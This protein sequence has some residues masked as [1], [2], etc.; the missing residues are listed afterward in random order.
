MSVRLMVRQRGEAGGHEK[1]T[2]V[3]I[4]K[5]RVTLGRDPSCE[6][7]LTQS[8]VSRQH[9]RLIRD[10]TLYFIED[11]GSSFGT[12]VN[13]QKLPKGEKRLL[14]AGDIIAIAQFDVTLEHAPGAALA[15][16]QPA[17]AQAQLA[18][19]ALKGT[20]KGLGGES[21][22]E[23]YFRV[24]NGPREGERIP[25]PTAKE[26]VVGRDESADLV[27]KD[28]LISRRHARLRRDWSGTHVEDLQSRNGVRVNR[29]RVTTTRTLRDRDEVEIGD[30]RLLYV[31]PNEVQNGL[32][33]VPMVPLRDD[34][35]DTRMPEPDEEPA[36]EEGADEP[37]EEN[38]APSPEEAEPPMDPVPSDAPEPPPEAGEEDGGLSESGSMAEDGSMA[39][40]ASVMEGSMIMEDSQGQPL[41]PMQR[42]LRSKR[43]L[44]IAIAA[45]VCGLA[46]LLILVLVL[47]GV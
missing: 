43:R 19:Q 16:G 41:P 23:P 47:A 7:V 17:E 20:L 6:V 3:P 46:L 15:E 13:G 4:D 44:A 9:A 40:E 10:G 36:P 32:R 11:L 27:F 21:G 35:E 14:R 26:W 8:A 29:K 18:R 1:P 37:Q 34:S 25:M 30:V 2:E 38:P 42:L 33:Q 24:M 31:D 12:Q 28:D 39:G 45:I 22:S 5:D